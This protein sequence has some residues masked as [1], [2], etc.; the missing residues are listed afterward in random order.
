MTIG[1][2]WQSYPQKAGKYL[3]DLVFPVS[4]LG[5]GGEGAWLCRDCLRTIPL[6]PSQHCPFCGR[7]AAFGAACDTCRPGRAL[8]GA[9]AFY[10]YAHPLIQTLIH[11][12]KYDG[13]MELT[14]ALGAVTAHGLNRTLVK[15]KRARSRL[16][17]GMDASGLRQWQNLPAPLLLPATI[18]CPI[19]LHARRLRQ[20]GFNQAE[21]LSYALGRYF[22]WPAKTLLARTRATAAQAKLA[23]TDRLINLNNA[24]ILTIPPDEISGKHILLVDDVITTGATAEAC[25][26]VLRQGGAASVWALTIAYGNPA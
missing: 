26:R 6:A 17:S 24:F 22:P 21:L 4:C 15:L 2:N 23:G 18:L 9:L 16:L 3:L 10:P 7:P 12:W 20:R 8:A 11:V 14:A 25:A 5:C 1:Y 19:P 13:V